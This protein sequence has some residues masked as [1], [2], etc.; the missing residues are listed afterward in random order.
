MKKWFMAIL[1]VALFALVA[2]SDST[3]ESSTE[4][5]SNSDDVTEEAT[6]EGKVT[7]WA[8]DVNFNIKALEIAQEHYQAINPDVEF[9]VIENAQDDIVQRLNTSLSSGTTRGLPNIVLIEDYRAQSFL[10][11]Y[12]DSFYPITGAFNADD[13][14]PYK[15]APTS[16][17]GENYG[18]PFDTGVTGLFVR[19]DYLEEAGYTADDLSII[20]W[21]E[22]IEIGKDVY[23]ATG[24]KMITTDP[25]DLGLIRTMIQSA[26]AW[27][28]EDDGVTPNLANNEA[29]KAS[30]EVYKKMVEADIMGFHSDWSQF[31][32]GFNSGDVAT[33]QTG[34]WISPSIRAE[35]S[36]AG[37]WK[38]VEQ[39][40]LSG[41]DG[42][43]NASNLGGSSWYVIDIDGKEDAVDFLTQTFGSN[44]DFYQDLVTE[45]GA[46]G[47]YS[48][49]AE[50]EAYQLED[51]Y[52]QGQRIIA[53]FS[54]WA[55]DIPQINYGM[56]TYAIDDILV[57]EM[58]NYLN[59]KD[60][61]DALAD[62]QAQ[63]EASLN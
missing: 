43:V 11:A 34:N 45:I 28:M 23:E 53:T 24:K 10:N 50:G 18:L 42:A 37:L 15:L 33:V 14:A 27:Y 35:D 1:M 30:F 21:E 25:S 62:A 3:E 12:P 61:D 22:Y 19:T 17:E 48:P 56:H 51:D 54:E 2:C 7:V 32:Q 5:G 58:Q 8:W 6:G 26:G 46:I 9:E 47:T 13:F 20:D 59:G 39:P 41:V 44:V 55:E 57:V 49:A 36:Q 63:A 29:L 16:F 31:L 38:V 52:F 60:L 4:N 40:R